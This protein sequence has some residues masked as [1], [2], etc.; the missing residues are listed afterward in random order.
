LANNEL[1]D[2]VKKFI[3][4]YIE[5]LTQLEVLLYF[6]NHQN[7]SFN[8]V[9]I[10]GELRNNPESV[11]VS[12][13]E[14]SGYGFI[15]PDKNENNRFEYDRSNENENCI[16]ELAQAYQTYRNTLITLIFSKP[17]QNVRSFADAF[18]IIKDKDNG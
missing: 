9:E 6:Y 10:A 13:K 2:E 8:A 16:R 14:L 18:K 15:L 4:N 17:S 12:L 7:K 11:S 5:S 3:Y 1:S